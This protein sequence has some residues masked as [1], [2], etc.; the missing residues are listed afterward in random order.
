M[1][2]Q[3]AGSESREEVDQQIGVGGPAGRIGRRRRDRAALQPVD[4]ALDP[5]PDR[6]LAGQR[7]ALQAGEL[8]EP[9][10]LPEV[11]IGADQALPI[12]AWIDFVKGRGS[13]TPS[14]IIARTRRGNM[15]A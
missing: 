4:Q 5:R 1:T 6:A 10:E 14:M 3:V 9:L 7:A 2:G 11:E 13:R 15:L 12:A 8:A